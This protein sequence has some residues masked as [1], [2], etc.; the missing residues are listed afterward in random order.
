ML[1]NIP[2]ATQVFQGWL[3]EVLPTYVV[4]PT[5]VVG[6]NRL[7]WLGLRHTYM[8]FWI[9][10]AGLTVCV[11]IYLE[12]PT[13]PNGYSIKKI[14]RKLILVVRLNITCL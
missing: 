7:Q 6:L 11:Y 3:A 1:V 13:D 9:Y 14:N 4:V 10:H 5:Q 2:A 8:Q 12:G